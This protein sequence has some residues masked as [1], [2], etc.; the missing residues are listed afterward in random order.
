MSD[1]GEE[2]E[3][4]RHGGRSEFVTSA[5]QQD[6]KQV[7]HLLTV[8]AVLLLRRRGRGAEEQ[9]SVLSADCRVLP[10]SVS[11]S[12]LS[13]VLLGKSEGCYCCVCV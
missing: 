11:S 7:V 3:R 12:T 2:A 8:D 6:V 9:R 1:G 5:L 13:C 4:R 10:H